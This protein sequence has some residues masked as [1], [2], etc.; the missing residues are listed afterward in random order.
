MTMTLADLETAREGRDFEAR[1][2]HSMGC[3]NAVP[4]G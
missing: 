4:A 1:N 3:S 2:A